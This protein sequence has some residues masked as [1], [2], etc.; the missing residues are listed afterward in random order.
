[1]NPKAAR[2]ATRGLGTR[3]WIQGI[4]C[5]AALTLATPAA[6]LALLLL[7]PS[8]A[9]L[10]LETDPGRPCGRTT[11]MAGIAAAINPVFSLW[12]SASPIGAAM[13]MASDP[14]ILLTCWLAQA[15][16]W[17]AQQLAP[18]IIR[19]IL[20]ANA[21]AHA[22]RLRGQRTE[23]ERDWGVPPAE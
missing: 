22:A 14:Q 2:K 19:L 23:L 21:T 1:M 7:V 12:S 18:L 5:G 13:A 6:V 10:S 20:E 3:T 11:L 9:A 15:G 16:A 4:A 8:L 17:L